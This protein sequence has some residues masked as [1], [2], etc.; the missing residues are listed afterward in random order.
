MTR[1]RLIGLAAGGLVLAGLAGG[2]GFWRLGEGPDGGATAFSREV[3]DGRGR[4]LRPFQ[5]DDDMWRFPGAVA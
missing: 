3:V 4:L 1:R 5:T 2:Y